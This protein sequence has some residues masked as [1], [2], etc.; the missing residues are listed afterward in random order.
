[1]MFDGLSW[2][3]PANAIVYYNPTEADGGGATYYFDADAQLVF[4]RTGFW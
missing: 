3:C 1:M 4:Q 2:E